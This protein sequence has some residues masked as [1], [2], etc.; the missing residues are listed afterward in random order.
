[1]SMIILLCS[2]TL[3]DGQTNAEL[4]DLVGLVPFSLVIRKCSLR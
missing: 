1:M 2:F 3:N 4:R